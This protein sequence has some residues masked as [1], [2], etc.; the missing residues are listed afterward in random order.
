MIVTLGESSFAAQAAG[1]GEHG[2]QNS[3]YRSPAALFLSFS[4]NR[5]DFLTPWPS[6]S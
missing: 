5:A 1:S 6:M 4:R 2:E 3:A